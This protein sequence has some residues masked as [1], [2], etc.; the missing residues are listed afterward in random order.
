MQGKTKE[1]VFDGNILTG[2]EGNSPDGHWV[3]LQLSRPSRVG[4]IR[5]IPR[6]DGNCIEVGDKYQLMMYDKQQWK[7]LAVRVAT[8]NVIM[9]SQ[10]PREGLFLLSNLTKGSEERIFTYENGKQLW[11]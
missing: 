6:N 9:F 2:F 3:G 1:T 4:K 11:W 5:F 10:I 7:V 8:S